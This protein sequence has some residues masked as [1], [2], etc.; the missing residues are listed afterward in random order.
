MSQKKLLVVDDEAEFGEF[1]EAAATR[2]D[3]E[4]EVAN[5]GKDF[6]DAYQRFDPTVI[7]LDM[8][9]PG[10]DG[11]ELVYWLADEGFSGKL[12]VITGYS[13]GYASSAKSLGEARGLQS[14]EA[15]GKPVRLAELRAALTA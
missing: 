15:L 9:M 7:M 3:F 8:V 12:I 11:V 10:I 13:A 6:K 14:V 5:N 2:L 4:V 1:V